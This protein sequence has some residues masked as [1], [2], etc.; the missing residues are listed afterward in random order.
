MKFGKTYFR[1][2]IQGLQIVV[3]SKYMCIFFSWNTCFNE[4]TVT[5]N[6]SSLRLLGKEVTVSPYSGKQI[7][8]R[9]YKTFLA[10]N[11]RCRPVPAYFTVNVNLRFSLHQQQFFNSSEKEVS[12][13]HLLEAQIRHRLNVFKLGFKA[14]NYFTYNCSNLTV[15]CFDM[16]FW[17]VFYQCSQKYLHFSVNTG[18]FEQEVTEEDYL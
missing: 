10:I 1:S 4:L 13:Q 8:I 12:V 14:D 3:P 18:K 16:N 7:F 11:E 17:E 5:T 9:C 15:L 2:C 6:Y